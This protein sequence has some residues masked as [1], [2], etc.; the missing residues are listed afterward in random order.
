MPSLIEIATSIGS[1]LEQKNKA[2]GSAFEEAGKVLALLYPRG[3]PL[4][5]YQD[6]LVITRILDKLFRIANQKDAFAEDPWRDIAGYAILSLW[7]QE[8]GEP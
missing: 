2:Y 3:V 1:L 7:S 6:M 8:K 4:E 5:G